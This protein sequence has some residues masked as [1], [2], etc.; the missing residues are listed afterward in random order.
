MSVRLV[1]LKN[2]TFRFSLIAA[3]LA[4][5]GEVGAIGLGE[6]R[7][8]AVL[9]D[10]ARFAVEILEAGQGA[11]EAAC[12][13]LIKPSGDEN[14]P[15]LKGGTL[16]VRNGTPPVLQIRSDTP[17]TDPALAVAV[18]VSCG[19]DVVREYVVLTTLPTE[20]ALQMA[21]PDGSRPAAAARPVERQRNREASP[22]VAT[23]RGE[24]LRGGS[25][26][27]VP[28]STPAAVV[29]DTARPEPADRLRNMEATIGELQQRAAELTKKIEQ[30]ATNPEAGQAGRPEATP[31]A[32]PPAPEQPTRIAP[33][34]SSSGGSGWTFYGT[35]FGALLALA[36]WW[37]W[38]SFRRR[39]PE[40][41]AGDADAEVDPQRKDEYDERGGVGLRVA[42]VAMAMPMRL[43]VD[44]D[45][46]A[47]A[48][49]V[50]TASSQDFINS[51][52][53]AEADQHL[54]INPAMELA[55]I[56]LSFGRVKGAAQTLQE[57]VESNPQEAVMPWIR[58]MEVCRMA[59]MRKE[60][61]KVALD[62]NKNFNVEIQKWEETAELES[63][64]A[65]DLI[66]D[67]E[68]VAVSKVEGIEAMPAVMER[69]VMRWQDGEVIDYLD[70]LLRD[71]R[72]GT[73]LGFSLPVVN[74]IQFLIDLKKI[75]N[76]I[77][78]ES[79]E[80]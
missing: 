47:A 49:D 66:L 71:N 19:H 73:R 67:T 4:L 9:G 68:P 65:V 36:A 18:Y 72:G 31:A 8:R 63:E 69:V 59:G 21:D 50:G 46:P 23:P 44:V 61:E 70:Q 32:L 33:V 64:G 53:G 1:S 16:T 40:G 60:F 41:P 77:E 10:R 56:M 17:L 48:P 78:S 11:P 22:A 42:P 55:E 35:L 6:L 43:D 74:D 7:G 57:F 80:S 58:L 75:S 24:A 12:F 52:V 5:C 20:R 45:A 51:I 26:P 76:K 34:T 13:R 54:E 3:L 27:L 29:Q 62:L 25:M 37:V 39:S 2:S 38:R 28:A 30:T 79:K 14:M 15:W